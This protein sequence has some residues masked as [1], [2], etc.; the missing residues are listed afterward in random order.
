[1]SVYVIWDPIYGGA[2]DREAKNL[3]VS[4][5]D[6]RVKYYKDPDSLAGKL[7]KRVLTLQN[8]DEVAW[9]VYLLYGADARWENDPPQPGFWTHQ[10]WGVTEAPRLDASTLTAK[11]K[12]MLAQ[13]KTSG[14][15]GSAPTKDYADA[16]QRIH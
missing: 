10:L 16:D 5:P 14:A 7:W 11:L 4:F 15:T 13:I 6:K 8:R 9:D 2:F 1:M 12:D 3:S